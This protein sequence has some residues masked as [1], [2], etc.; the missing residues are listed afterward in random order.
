M[1]VYLGAVL[2]LTIIAYAVQTKLTP[3]QPDKYAPA[4]REEPQLRVQHD[5]EFDHAGV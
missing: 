3:E 1:W 4:A 5:E 2:I